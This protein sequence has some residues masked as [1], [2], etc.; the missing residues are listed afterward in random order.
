MMP[1]DKPRANL[2]VG[3]VEEFCEVCGNSMWNEVHLYNEARY[4]IDFPGKNMCYSCVQ[5][6]L[7]VR[8]PGFD[9]QQQEKYIRQEIYL[10]EDHW[11]TRVALVVVIKGNR[12]STSNQE[13]YREICQKLVVESFYEMRICADEQLRHPCLQAGKHLGQTAGYPQF[14]MQCLGQVS[15][16]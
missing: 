5:Q 6:E 14:C 4:C 13:I 10:T 9:L 1:I 16:M 15:E 8:F 3:S 11:K 12:R 7:G 2:P